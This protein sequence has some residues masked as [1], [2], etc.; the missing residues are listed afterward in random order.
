VFVSFDE[1][2]SLFLPWTW[3]TGLRLDRMAEPIE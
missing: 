1:T 2:T 3:F